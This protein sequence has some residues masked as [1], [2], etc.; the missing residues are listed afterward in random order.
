MSG[1]VEWRLVGN[2]GSKNRTRTTII[3]ISSNNKDTS[4]TAARRCPE[5]GTAAAHDATTRRLM[6][7]GETSSAGCGVGRSAPGEGT[8]AAVN[9]AARDAP[10]LV[11][12]ARRDTQASWGLGGRG[13]TRARGTCTPHGKNT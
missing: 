5:H 9:E 2:T 13:A 4:R 6:T 8:R 12:K 10:P 3:P 1:R 7:A 11:I